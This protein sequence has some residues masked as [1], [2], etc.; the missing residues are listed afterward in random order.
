MAAD[1]IQ[2]ATTT[3]RCMDFTSNECQEGSVCSPTTTVRSAGSLEFWVAIDIAIAIA[4]RIRERVKQGRNKTRDSIQAF[5]L[6]GLK[7]AKACLG[8]RRLTIQYN[9]IQYTGQKNEA[10]SVADPR[11]RALVSSEN[12]V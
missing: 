8:H 9:T 4:S 11:S 12:T 10:E 3:K 7:T 1:A 6:D 5:C 2:E